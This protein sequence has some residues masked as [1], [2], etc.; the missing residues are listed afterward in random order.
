MSPTTVVGKILLDG[1]VYETNREGEHL[2]PGLDGN[3]QSSAGDL[4]T[5][6]LKIVSF[7]SRS[8][9]QDSVI[10]PNAL[11]RSNLGECSALLTNSC[12]DDPLYRIPSTSSNPNFGTQAFNDYPRIVYPDSRMVDRCKDLSCSST[13]NPVSPGF[14]AAGYLSIGCITAGNCDR[15]I[16]AAGQSMAAYYLGGEPANSNANPNATTSLL[17]WIN[18]QPDANSVGRFEYFQGAAP[19][20]GAASFARPLLVNSGVPSFVL[21]VGE[22]VYKIGSAVTQDPKL[23]TSSTGVA[24]R[25][26]LAVNRGIMAGDGVVLQTDGTSAYKTS[27]PNSPSVVTIENFAVPLFTT[28]TPNIAS[29]A[30][31][32]TS[33]RPASALPTTPVLVTT[34]PPVDAIDPSAAITPL[35]GLEI[36]GRTSGEGDSAIDGPYEQSDA[37]PETD[38]RK[39][40]PLLV[41]GG[42]G[43]AQSVDLGRSGGLGSAR[44]SR[45]K[46]VYEVAC[47]AEPARGGGSATPSPVRR[48]TALPACR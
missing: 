20:S 48:E 5:V 42:R 3:V 18:V 46:V 9:Y 32:G 39:S 4:R 1:R 8:I 6:A 45:A 36:T 12:L 21:G 26:V 27:L 22:N 47:A 28:L 41:L 16:P 34:L 23:A 10:A 30:S 25:T 2:V 14:Q 31:N 17:S 19:G 24:A 33:L 13:F 43:L 11:G 15:P 7:D 37:S 38:A 29:I 44:S 35:T 40:A